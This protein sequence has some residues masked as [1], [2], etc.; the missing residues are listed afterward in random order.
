MGISVLNCKGKLNTSHYFWE[1]FRCDIRDQ[2]TKLHQKVPR[3]FDLQE[4]SSDVT[5]PY[6]SWHQ[7]GVPK[8]SPYCHQGWRS[9]FPKVMSADM[10]VLPAVIS[11]VT[12]INIT[13]TYNHSCYFHKVRPT[14]A[15]INIACSQTHSCYH[16]YYLH[17]YPKLLSSILPAASHT[18]SLIITSDTVVLPITMPRCCD[19]TFWA[20]KL[21]VG[22][23]G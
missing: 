1:F 16:Q 20:W 7:E 17:P 4:L 8:V 11:W 19:A 14:V 15:I 2:S 13:F 12:F 21:W 5:H 6:I 23:S 3:P 18:V 22:T 9:T 10:N